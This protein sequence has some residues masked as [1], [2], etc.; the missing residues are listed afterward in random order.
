MPFLER[1]CKI[2]PL[3]YNFGALAGGLDCFPLARFAK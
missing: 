1:S 3:N 2:G